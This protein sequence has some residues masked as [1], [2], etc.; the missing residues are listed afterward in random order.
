MK[1][2][3]LELSDGRLYLGQEVD[4]LTP[5]AVYLGDGVV[6]GFAPDAVEYHQLEK[7]SD[8]HHVEEEFDR[9]VLWSASDTLGR[10]Q[11]LA[12]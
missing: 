12:F 4:G 2:S 10:L 7:L 11:A 6:R 3:E 9:F 8:D 5:V 1:I